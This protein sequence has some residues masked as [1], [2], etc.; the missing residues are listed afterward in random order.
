MA[1]KVDPEIAKLIKAAEAHGCTV[2]QTKGGHWKVKVPG[3]GIVV[4][5]STP[6][7][8]RGTKNARSRLRQ[9]GVDV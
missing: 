2:E 9:M 7:D 8:K 4:L 5:A 1:R 6:S 3:A